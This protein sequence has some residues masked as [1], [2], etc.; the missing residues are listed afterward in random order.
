MITDNLLAQTERA[1]NRYY[2]LSN[3]VDN[4]LKD[5]LNELSETVHSIENGVPIERMELLLFIDD[6]DNLF[7]EYC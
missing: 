2:L 7:Q 3:I 6:I 5:S 4:D 1:I